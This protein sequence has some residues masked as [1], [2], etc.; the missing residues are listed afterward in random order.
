MKTAINTH[1]FCM[2]FSEHR[3]SQNGLF[4]FNQ[5][6]HLLFNGANDHRQ[7]EPSLRGTTFTSHCSPKVPPP[8]VQLGASANRP[9]L[10][11][12]VQGSSKNDIAPRSGLFGE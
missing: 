7:R 3:D 2:F 6:P 10:V 12:P 5:M 8:K 11:T 1:V 4:L 9:F